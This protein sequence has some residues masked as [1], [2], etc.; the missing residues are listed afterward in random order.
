[1]L[2]LVVVCVRVAMPFALHAY[3]NRLLAHNPRYTGTVGDVDIALYRG[4]YKIHDVDVRKRGA[5]VPVPFLAAPLVDV[6]LE[7]RSVFKGKLVGQV[8]LQSPELNFVAGPTD[9]QRQSGNEGEWKKLVEALFP[10]QLNRF[11]VSD[12]KI[13][14]RNFTSKPKVDVALYHVDLVAQDLSRGGDS[15]DPRPA[16]LELRGDF[17]PTGHVV[18]H[19]ALDPKAK[20]P[21]FDSD[22]VVKGAELAQWNDFLRAYANVDAKEGHLTLYAELLAEDGGFRG[23]AK[24]FLTDVQVLD[25]KDVVKQDLLSTAWQAFVQGVIEVFRNHEDDDVATRIPITGEKRPRGE[26]WPALGN[27]LYNAF[28]EGLAPRLEHSV[29][30]RPAAS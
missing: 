22:L 23:Y 28:I 10:T 2:A 15:Q 26:F 24:P 6:S 18:L 30:D 19:M 11:E 3:L 21:S 29:G 4:A 14:F 13:H 1:M 8:V 9:A 25:W 17:E 20:A 16:R 7:W 27:T 5:K 12:G